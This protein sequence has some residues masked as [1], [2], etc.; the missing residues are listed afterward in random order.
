MSGTRVTPARVSERK[1]TSRTGGS[2]RRTLHVHDAFPLRTVA[3]TTGLTPDLIRAWE[4]RYGVVAP[5]RGARGARLYTSADVAHLRLLARVVA[6]G[7]AIGDVAALSLS[8]L[9]QLAAQKPVEGQAPLEDEPR[10]ARQQLVTQIVERLECFDRAAV[11]R[12]LGDAVIGLGCRAF[13]HQIAAPLLEEVGDRWSHGSLAIAHEHLL[14]GLLRNLLASL[15]HARARSRSRTAVLAA[16]AGERH[17]FGLLLVAL[18]ALDAG[19][20]VAHLGADLPASEIVAAVR[21]SNAIL[22]GL[23]LVSEDNRSAA[24]REVQAIQRAVPASVELWCGGRD[25][26]A[27]AARLKSFRG[28]VVDTL[29]LAEAELDRLGATARWGNA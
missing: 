7:R 9:E 5:I 4:K 22:L 19:L 12:L 2:Q 16:P 29:S 27:V 28:R 21:R 3:A 15:I 24:V 26:G 23:S 11:A 13:V 17:E 10:T 1:S 18:L 25:A 8:E 6:A 14:S 20:D